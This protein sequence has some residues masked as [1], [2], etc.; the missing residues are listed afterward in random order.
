MFNQCE[1]VQIRETQLG[2][3]SIKTCPADMLTEGSLL[4]LVI[5][6]THYT[7]TSYNG[8]TCLMKKGS[9]S[10][11]DAFYVAK[12]DY[13]CGVNPS[14]GGSIRFGIFANRQFSKKLC[15]FPKICAIFQKNVQL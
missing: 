2:E 5:G 6:C 15:N 9:V 7:W 14:S 1:L 13:V 12:P 4:S 8:G 3:G 11:S 10:K